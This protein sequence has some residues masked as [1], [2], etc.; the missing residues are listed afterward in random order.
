MKK[1]N[2]AEGVTAVKAGLVMQVP[3]ATV[4]GSGSG[5]GAGMAGLGFA[6][7]AWVPAERMR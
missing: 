5:P 1:T 7:P 2:T 4:T 6:R 3:V